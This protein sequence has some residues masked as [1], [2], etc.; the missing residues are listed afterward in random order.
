M[1]ADLKMKSQF[2][3]LC[4][5]GPNTVNAVRGA[6][7]SF[8]AEQFQTPRQSSFTCQGSDKKM[9]AI[10]RNVPQLTIEVCSK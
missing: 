8:G 1:F 7:Q 4:A 5:W 9:Y 3:S 2:L 10:I 6:V